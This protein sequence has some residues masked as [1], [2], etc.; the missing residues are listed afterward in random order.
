[1]NQS[2]IRE[3]LE[4]ELTILAEE[5]RCFPKDPAGIANAI[6]SIASYLMIDQTAQSDYSPLFN[7]DSSL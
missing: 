6:L 7:S 3:L 4:R 2:Q 5:A 1:M